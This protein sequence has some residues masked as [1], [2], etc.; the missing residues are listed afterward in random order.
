[1]FNLHKATVIVLLEPMNSGL[2]DTIM[3]YLSCYIPWQYT[4]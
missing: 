2:F 1:M 3:N 4:V